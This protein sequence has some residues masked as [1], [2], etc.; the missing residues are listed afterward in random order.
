M[1]ADDVVL[2]TQ[3]DCAAS[4]QV[5]GWLTNRG[6]RF[7]ERDAGADPAAAAALAATGLFATPLLVVGGA[8]VFG[9]QPEAL[10]AATGVES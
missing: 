4:R 7:V 3:R 6:V 10:A 2:Y 8:N 1:P 9:F 5:R